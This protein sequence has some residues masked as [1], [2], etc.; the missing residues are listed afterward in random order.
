[1]SRDVP[2]Y[3]LPG[4]STAVLGHWELLTADSWEV[5]PSELPDW[6]ATVSLVIR[7]SA[8]V[9]LDRLRA[10]TH[11]APEARVGWTVSWISST[12]KMRGTAPAT[13]ITGSGTRSIEA[14]LPGDRIGGT[15][16]LHT[17]LALLRTSTRL[18]PGA[19]HRP[20]SVLLRDTVGVT[21]GSASAGFPVATIDFAATRLDPHTSWHLET[22]TDLLAPFL[23]TVLLLINTRD[24][25]LV[26]AV[27]T[28][29]PDRRQES[30][31]DDLDNSVAALLLELAAHHRAELADASHWPPGS[32]GE[33]L[34]RT[35]SRAERSGPIHTP[36]GP[37]DLPRVRSRLSGVARALGHGRTFL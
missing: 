5:L 13:P 19:P 21:L 11:I 14:Q 7:R 23:G 10:E 26:K 17:S 30:L 1:M 8:T 37:H 4:P 6:D 24:T 25:E 20:G 27:T 22:T 31:L 16:T 34:Q 12:S 15:L 32:L 18:R 28:P 33:A 3:L 36:K 2:P 9:D 35:L 29:R